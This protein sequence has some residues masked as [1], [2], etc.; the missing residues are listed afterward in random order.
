[1][2]RSRVDST[3]RVWLSSRASSAHGCLDRHGAGP[4]VWTDFD[5]R[6]RDR[7]LS[8]TSQSQYLTKTEV[9]VA[10]L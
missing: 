2:R 9:Y 1:M 3:S 4:L 5:M 6:R 7:I 8:A 10:S